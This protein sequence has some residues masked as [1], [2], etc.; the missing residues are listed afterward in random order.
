MYIDVYSYPFL[1]AINPSSE[2]NE[3]EYSD[4]KFAA[5]AAGWSPANASA[6]TGKRLRCLRAVSSTQTS[7][8]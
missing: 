8:R 6:V 2:E 7:A 5:I 4:E 3:S 1:R